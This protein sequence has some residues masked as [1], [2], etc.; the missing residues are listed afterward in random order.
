[1]RREELDLE[2][3]KLREDEQYAARGYKIVEFPTGAGRLILDLD[4][5]NLILVKQTIH[6]AVS[7][8]LKTVRFFDPTDKAKAD[9]ILADDRT[10]A[11]LGFDAIVQLLLLGAATNPNFLLGS[12]APQIRVTTTLKALQSGD[13]IVRVEGSSALMSMR[14]LKRLECTGGVTA[15][16]FDE[17]LLPLDVGREQR[18]FTRAQSTAIAVKW[19]GCAAEGCDAPISWTENHH[20]DEWAADRGQTNVADGVPLCKPHHLLFHNNGWHIKRND[21]G[22]YWLIPP[23]SV[24]SDQTPRQLKPKTGNMRDLRNAQTG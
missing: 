15:L 3:V 17:N 16:L 22:E 11:Q 18:L 9:T 10:P 19:G 7:P 1:M 2:S 13:G 20:I 14:T 12:G 5:E 4:P 21:Q 6:R 23:P 24:D 8:K